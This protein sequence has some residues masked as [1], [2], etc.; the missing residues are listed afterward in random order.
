MSEEN[1]WIKIVE[2]LN[3]LGTQSPRTQARE[4]GRNETV[5]CWISRIYPILLSVISINLCFITAI[6]VVV[7]A[8]VVVVFIS[9]MMLCWG[10]V[11][12]GGT[13]GKPP[14]SGSPAPL[15]RWRT[16]SCPGFFLRLD[17]GTGAPQFF[18]CPQSFSLLLFWFNFSL[19]YF[20]S[21]QNLYL[22]HFFL[23]FVPK[24]LC[25]RTPRPQDGGSPRPP[26][27]LEGIPAPAWLLVL[28]LSGG[29]RRLCGAHAA[30]Q[31]LPFAWADS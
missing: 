13:L 6:V 1:E 27:V 30:N 11:C 3:E 12:K 19:F 25:P 24:I 9:A 22:I 29:P 28:D 18:L 15:S 8:F 26:P 14:C 23:N 7:F 2:R 5:I 16:S 21:V 10:G 20:I 17:P 31:P 4:H